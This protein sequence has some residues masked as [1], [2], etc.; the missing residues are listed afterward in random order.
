MTYKLGPQARQLL[1]RMQDCI[2]C[3]LILTN[4]S[5]ESHRAEEHVL[6]DAEKLLFIFMR[7]ATASQ[8][9]DPFICTFRF[10]APCFALLSDYLASKLKS[11]IF[12]MTPG[13]HYG[14]R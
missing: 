7:P 3:I 8:R 14:E 13:H 6:T 10:F 5:P 11:K 4:H 12:A 1:I 9:D 2:C